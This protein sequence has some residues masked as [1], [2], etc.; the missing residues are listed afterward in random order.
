MWRGNIQ[1]MV[2]HGV[3]RIIRPSLPTTMVPQIFQLPNELLTRILLYLDLPSL[4][5]IEEVD[6]GF[7][8]LAQTPTLR[9]HYVTTM[10]QLRCTSGG[11]VSIDD[12]LLQ[13]EAA[14]SAWKA[15][16]PVCTLRRSIPPDT[17]GL[18]ELSGGYIFFG[19][20]D[21]RQEIYHMPLPTPDAPDPEWSLLNIGQYII[22]FALVSSSI[23]PLWKV[24]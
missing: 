23:F 13:V 6:P 2:A 4:K 8:A 16:K 14:E 12:V 15:F 1:H 21:Q 3:C 20:G 5:A 9:K 7:A 18:Y 10:A 17:A 24:L 22:D 19:K 11:D